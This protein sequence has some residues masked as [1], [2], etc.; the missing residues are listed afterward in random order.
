MIKTYWVRFSDKYNKMAQRE[1]AILLIAVLAVIYLLWSM[2]F[3]A[4]VG[5]KIEELRSQV[6]NAESRQLDLEAQAKVFAE[7]ATQDPNAGRKRQ[8]EQLQQR[9]DS[10]DQELQALSVGLVPAEML[11]QV[12]HDVLA[13]TDE[14]ELLGMQTL[15]IQR[16]ALTKDSGTAGEE[17]DPDEASVYRHAVEVKV[18]GNYFAVASYLQ[19]LENLQWRFYWDALRYEVEGY[20][21]AVATL[22]VYT[23]SAGEGVLG[24]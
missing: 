8:I 2:L 6:Q 11:P 9:L 3:L 20:P 24:E 5:L 13:Q 14:L 12:L 17:T 4:P 15:P 22:E 1:R 21:K 19:E 10:L 23:L 16:L 7:A 18:R